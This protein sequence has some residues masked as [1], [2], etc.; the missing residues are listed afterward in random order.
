MNSR[1]IVAQ[2]LAGAVDDIGGCGVQRRNLVQDKL[3][4]GHSLRDGHSC[5]QRTN[6]R[7][8]RAVHALDQLDIVLLHQIKREIALN[9]HRHLR[10]QILRALAHIE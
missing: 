6:R 10:Q 7:C 1:S 3:L 5:T 9:C 2:Q 4:I 8:R